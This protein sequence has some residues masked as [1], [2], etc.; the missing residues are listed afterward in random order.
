VATTTI[1]SGI[2][3]W[4]HLRESGGL[5]VERYDADIVD[6]I[7][8]H[9]G[10]PAGTSIE[11]GL[12]T[13]QI[14][15]D[16]LI[17]A[18]LRAVAPYSA[19]MNELLSMFARAGAQAS[20]EN[21]L[22]RF[23]FDSKVEG[24]AF[25][26]ESF[27]QWS[28]RW[29]EETRS[30]RILTWQSKLLWRLVPAFGQ[31]PYAQRSVIGEPRAREWL[32]L[33][34]GEKKWPEFD[35]PRPEVGVELQGL[36]DETWTALEAFLDD[37]RQFG[38]SRE[39]LER[40]IAGTDERPDVDSPAAEDVVR[41][42]TLRHIDS[43]GWAG[44]L[45]SAAYK[46]SEH[47]PGS[48]STAEA[49]AALQSILSEVPR[50]DRVLTVK[51]E[52]LDDLLNLPVWKHRHE[53]Y[54]AWVGSRVA[55]ALGDPER[56]TV[57]Q[58]GGRILYRFSGTHLATAH[59]PT[60]ER[61]DVWS[62]L[63]SPTAGLK[64]KGRSRSIQPDYSVA[65]APVTDP[66]STILVVECKQYLKA[67]PANFS[68]ALEDYAKGRPKAL[69][70][71]AGYGSTAERILER[72]DPEVRS[73]TRIVSHL[74]PDRPDSLAAFQQAVVHALAPANGCSSP[75]SEPAAAST[76]RFSPTTARITLS[77]QARVDLDLH[78][79]YR[80][81]AASPL[82]HISYSNLGDLARPPF[83]AL[84]ADVRTAGEETVSLGRVLPGTYS[85]AVHR[86]SPSGSVAESMAAVTADFDG[87]RIQM[88]GPA[89]Q[90]P[91]WHVLV[92]DSTRGSLQLS[93]RTSSAPP[94]YDG[95]PA[96]RAG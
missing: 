36:V 7:R 30:M 93:N 40:K 39:D 77:W 68:A 55:K 20:S 10:F 12:K 6:D 73:R 72:V 43:D 78:A 74:R 90:G 59:T 85:I 63:R 22:L 86:Y 44:S 45:V 54:S 95:S 8:R 65:R 41:R 26:L 64:R 80:A 58:C 51:V 31:F 76:S 87:L 60:G 19:M 79:W 16:R 91:W 11:R 33:Y 96:Q 34:D 75:T 17:R 35:L 38:P 47:A 25:D 1:K 71:L 56:V 83:V 24:L 69:V 29:V 21:L 4:R 89:Q 53:L 13:A 82:V 57:H 62:E 32:R 52:T 48:A 18:F 88:P 49:R 42:G 67:S 27:R 5:D 9:I 15:P 66:D 92:F 81:S 94:D 14:S 3:L 50:Q 28:R 46:F 37:A 70:V 84:A 61:L 2:Q 23:D